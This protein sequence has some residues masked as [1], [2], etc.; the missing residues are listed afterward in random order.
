MDSRAPDPPPRPAGGEGRAGLL[1]RRGL[2]YSVTDLHEPRGVTRPSVQPRRP[3]AQAPWPPRACLH[4]RSPFSRP[5]TPASSSGFLPP[6]PA[7]ALLPFHSALLFATLSP[8]FSSLS[9]VSAALTLPPAT[10]GNDWL[11]KGVG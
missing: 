1:H 10:T 3:H 7:F 2:Q 5:G 6:I 4:G 9:H 8:E 11:P